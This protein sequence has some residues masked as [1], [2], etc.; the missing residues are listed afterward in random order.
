MGAR[1][2]NKM[3]KTQQ[4]HQNVFTRNKKIAFNIF[5]KRTTGMELFGVHLEHHNTIRIRT[6]KADAGNKH[7]ENRD[8][9]KLHIQSYTKISYVTECAFKS[10][11]YNNT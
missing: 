9:P 8:A 1:F 6:S 3:N 5:Q 2:T 10:I 4:T 7:Q 11:Y